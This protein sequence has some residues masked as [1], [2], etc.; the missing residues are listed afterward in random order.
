MPE[1]HASAPGPVA[2]GASEV[3]SGA[4]P[5]GRGS[6]L[7]RRRVLDAAVVFV[8]QQGLRRLT[9]RRLGAFLGVNAMALYRYVPSRENLLDG[10][11]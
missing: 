10:V 4:H 9:M 3:P 6:P 8:D 2:F 5:T 11:V 7:D 1:H